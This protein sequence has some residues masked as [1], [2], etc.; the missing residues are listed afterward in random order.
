M[1]LFVCHWE[2]GRA[3]YVPDLTVPRL[4]SSTRRLADTV[5]AP[6]AADLEGE[7]RGRV[8]AMAADGGNPRFGGAWANGEGT[9]G[10]S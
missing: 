2:A 3:I 5:P 9:N 1:G 6:R 8:T 10:V 4:D 7:G